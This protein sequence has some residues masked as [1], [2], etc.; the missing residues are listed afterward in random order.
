MRISR[1]SWPVL[2]RSE[3]LGHSARHLACV[4][5]AEPTISR[6]SRRRQS[7]RSTRRQGASRSSSVWLPNGVAHAQRESRPFLGVLSEQAQARL[8]DLVVTTAWPSIALLP[9]GLEGAVCLE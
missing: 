3:H 9:V 1:L 8:G 6:R 4:R 5:F 2:G 7:R